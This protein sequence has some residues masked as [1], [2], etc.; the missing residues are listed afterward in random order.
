MD[1]R[2][3]ASHAIEEGI[4]R[5]AQLQRAP[6]PQ[7]TRWVASAAVSEKEPRADEQAAADAICAVEDVA[8]RKFEPNGRDTAPDWRMWM[9][10]GRRVAD[11]EVI[12][13]TNQAALEFTRALSTGNSAEKTYPDPRLFHEWTIAVGDVSPQ[14]GD[15]FVGPLMKAIRDV[16]ATVENQGHSPEQT[17]EAAGRELRLDGAVLRCCGQ[18]RL[19]HVMKVPRH[20]GPGFGTVRALPFAVRS[21][22]GDYD[23]LVPVIQDCIAKKTDQRKLDGAPGLKWLAVKLEVEGVPAFQLRNLFG[24][25]ASPHPTLDAIT[26][27]YFHEVWVVAWASVGEDRREGFTVL[28]L[29]DSGRDQQH[30]VVPRPSAA[31]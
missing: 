27:D 5:R 6:R 26:F 24:L 4:G 7:N 18:R 22:W 19:V 21:G 9:A 10:D 30:Y 12:R 15:R 8:D 28:R 29:S 31:A 16:L 20:V 17:M 3:T 2:S 23:P 13:G 25:E 11:V 14:I 1:G